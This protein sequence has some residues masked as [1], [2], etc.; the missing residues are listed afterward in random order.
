[1]AAT[2]YTYKA[3]SD[4]SQVSAD[5]GLFL[6]G[7]TD[8][9]LLS[10]SC[11]QVSTEIISTDVAGWTAEAATGLIDVYD[12]GTITSMTVYDAIYISS[13]SLWVIASSTG[14]YTSTDRK[15]LTLRDST[16]SVRGLTWNGTAVIGQVAAGTN[17]MR[18]STDAIT[19][20]ASTT[21]INV[22]SG[23]V[24]PCAKSGT[25]YLPTNLS[26]ATVALYTSTDN[27]ANYTSRA[28]PSGTYTCAATD[29]TVVLI[30]GASIAATNSS[31]DG[32]GTWTQSTGLPAGTYNDVI[33]N[34][35]NFI[36][37]GNSGICATSSTGLSGSWTQRTLPDSNSY[38]SIEYDGTAVYAVSNS[39]TAIQSLDNGVTWVARTIPANVTALGT[40][41]GEYFLGANSTITY[42]A[43]KDKTNKVFKAICA[44]ATRY[45][46][47]H[48]D[49]GY[50]TTS[51]A[52]LFFKA[53]TGFSSG[54]GTGKCY[55]SD[56]TTAAQRI[57]I[58]NGGTLF[59]K[60][61]NRIMFC[62]S[63]LSS[64]SSYGSSTGNGALIVG[65]HTME[66][67]WNTSGSAYP[68]FAWC[69]T[70][71]LTTQWYSPKLK[72]SVSGDVTGA[73]AVMTMVANRTNTKAS[74][75]ADGS[76]VYTGLDI[77]VY[78]NTTTN[79]VDGGRILGDIKTITDSM[80]SQQDRWNDNG[81]TYWKVF[82]SGTG[83]S[84]SRIAVGW[85]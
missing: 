24:R 84:T 70:N 11:V 10:A 25:I 2:Q 20:T 31:A 36:A 13:L 66:D 57:D 6:T 82:F 62:M 51:L 72:D 47:I 12:S 48:V 3:G 21:S 9:S 30:M 81:S 60:A 73:S 39:G 32:S 7:T 46:Y 41:S 35:T 52:Y 19:W 56:L 83:I 80:F 17:T 18:K 34:G 69:N 4:L 27:G 22:T 38:N 14:I 79:K 28:T 63:F 61:N 37:V 1:M 76:P 42:L 85:Y 5:I 45:K 68:T 43:A 44:D 78:S 16:S 58:L 64:G 33:W 23:Q 50:S 53:Y 71:T 74:L 55:N 26:S 49:I 40:D 29:G 59:L 77:E 65:E 15:I 75:K 8:K 54:V 67:L